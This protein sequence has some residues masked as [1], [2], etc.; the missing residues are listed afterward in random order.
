[1]SQLVLHTYINGKFYKGNTPLLKVNDIGLYRAYAVFDYLRSYNKTLFRAED[2]AERFLFSASEMQMQSPISKTA[3]LE[4]LN[5]LN[6]LTNLPDVGTR[7]LLTGGYTKDGITPEKPNLIISSEWFQPLIKEQYQKGVKIITENFK[8]YQPHIKTNNY[9]HV[10]K[11]R[12]E[13]KINEVYDVLYCYNDKVLETSR[14]NI[15]IFNGNTLVT[16]KKNILHGI[17]RKVVLELAQN[18][19]TTE[20]REISKKELFEAEEVFLTGTTKKVLPV[21][22]INNQL[23]S[24]GRIGGK[25]KELLKLFDSYIQEYK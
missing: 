16:P 9:A 12:R 25:T 11:L 13:K 15:F 17:T 21:T 7:L 3:L 24:K 14:N 5:Q 8:R 2:Y 22:I 4:I 20:E 1:M 19:F 6:Q 10:I 18:K 23:F